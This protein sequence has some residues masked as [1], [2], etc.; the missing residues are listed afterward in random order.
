M[1]VGLNGA[2]VHTRR[3]AAGLSVATLADRVGAHADV[4]WAIEEDDERHLEQFPVVTLVSLANSLDLSTRQLFADTEVPSTAPPAPDDVTLEAALLEHGATVTCEDL[5]LAFGWPVA[6]IELALAALHQRLASTGARLHPVGIDRYSVAPNRRALTADQ[7]IQLGQARSAHTP[8]TPE[9]A[10]AL[11][12]IIVLNAG[13]FPTSRR[14]RS[15]AP[16]AWRTDEW[17]DADQ[18][19]RQLRDQG[20][21]AADG[22]NFSLNQD[23]RYSLGLEELSNTAILVAHNENDSAA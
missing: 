7:W 12:Q 1:V 23:V 5:A 16:S 4:I 22:P 19:L 21:L 3:V 6:R 15:Q 13:S 9:A 11:Y 14:R 17:D 20:L 2:L 18:G 10:T 8:L